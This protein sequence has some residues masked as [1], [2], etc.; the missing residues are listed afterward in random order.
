MRSGFI[1]K[2][3]NGKKFARKKSFTGHFSNLPLRIV[4]D[5]HPSLFFSS[6]A[7]DTNTFT[8][9][10]Q[11]GFPKVLPTKIPASEAQIASSNL[12]NRSFGLLPFVTILCQHSLLLNIR[13]SSGLS[14]LP[15]IRMNQ[16]PSLFLDPLRQSW[17]DRWDSHQLGKASLLDI[18]DRFES[19]I[20]QHP[21]ANPSNPLQSDQLHKLR[22]NPFRHP[23][24]QHLQRRG[25]VPVPKQS[26][27][28][29]TSIDQPFR[30]LDQPCQISRLELSQLQN[31]LLRRLINPIQQYL[32]SLHFRQELLVGQGIL[33]LVRRFKH[34][35]V[36]MLAGQ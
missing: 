16:S 27:Q 1:F 33:E 23:H 15:L 6:H 10:L 19:S 17:T 25:Q 7:D 14:L 5:P 36:T 4:I 20:V 12:H 21:S 35:L 11:A 34:K 9:I 30:A 32:N 22:P 28:L 8:H 3:L 13:W 31:L 2:T 26:S 29:L 18:L 24:P